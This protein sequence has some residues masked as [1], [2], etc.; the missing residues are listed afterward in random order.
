MWLYQVFK[1]FALTHRCFSPPKSVSDKS[2]CRA[3]VVHTDNPHTHQMISLD[4]AE[5][6][7]SDNHTSEQ[8]NLDTCPSKSGNMRNPSDYLS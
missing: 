4:S 7:G 5:F 1:L 6:E 2:Q 8:Y 3:N